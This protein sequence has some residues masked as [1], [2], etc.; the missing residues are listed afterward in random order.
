[1]HA[2]T[3]ARFLAI[4]KHCDSQHLAKLEPNLLK[5]SFRP[6]VILTADDDV[7]VSCGP[8]SLEIDLRHPRRHRKP[9]NYLVRNILLVQRCGNP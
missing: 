4:N 9:A 6:T 7:D 3:D 5:S 8:H 1:M 2:A